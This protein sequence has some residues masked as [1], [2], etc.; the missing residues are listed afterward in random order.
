MTKVCKKH[1][2]NPVFIYGQCIGC[3]IEELRRQRAWVQ[4]VDKDLAH[5]IWAAAQLLPGEGIED[6]VERI[7]EILEETRK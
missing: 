2:K 4:A 7:I 6:G 1:Q 5:E 3:E